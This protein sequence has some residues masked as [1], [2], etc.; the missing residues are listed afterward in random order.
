MI[1]SSSTI[2]TLGILPFP[3]AAGKAS[4]KRND[5][6]GKGGG[7]TTGLPLNETGNAVVLGNSGLESSTGVVTCLE[8]YGIGS[9]SGMSSLASLDLFKQPSIL[10]P[11]ATDSC[12]WTISAS[13]FAVECTTIKVA[14]M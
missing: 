12:S 6:H 11:S 5:I 7:P 3:F 1:G 13:T 2:R 14:R 8:R 4:K 9:R 10:A